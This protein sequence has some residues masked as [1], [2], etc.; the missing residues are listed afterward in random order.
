MPSSVVHV[1]FAFLVAIGLLGR[2]YDRRA[3][4]VLLVIVLLPELDTVLGYVFSGGHRTVLHTTLIP[5][6]AA[7]LLFWETTRQDSWISERW[8]EWGV[9]IAWVGLFVHSFP[10][11]ALDWAH[12]S[13]INYFWPLVDQFYN[14][15]GELYLS[16]T[17]G[18]VQ[19]FVEI[20]RDPETGR[21]VVDAGKTGTRS[22]IHIANPAQPTS[23][24]TP[25]PVDRRFP[26]A[27]WGWQLY[28][29]LTSLFVLGCK[30]LQTSNERPGSESE[31]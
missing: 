6:L 31:S 11:I 21:R 20:S 26:I 10:H 8:G 7:P 16:T 9:R 4:A 2:F 27:V 5:M 13:G 15:D 19:T 14:L 3:L 25:E 29:V 23:E 30:K 22:E 12:L 17:E 28:I 18:F 1:A 24:P